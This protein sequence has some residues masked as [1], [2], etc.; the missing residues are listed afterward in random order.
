MLCR[1]AASFSLQG[2]LYLAQYETQHGDKYNTLLG[3]LRQEKMINMLLVSLKKRQSVLTWSQ[4]VS[5][6]NWTVHEENS[7]TSDGICLHNGCRT[8][9]LWWISQST[10]MAAYTHSSWSWLCGKQL[11]VQASDVLFEIQL[12][13]TD[14]SVI[15]IWRIAP[16]GLDTFYQ[17]LL[18]GYNKLTAVFAKVLCMFGTPYLCEQVFSVMNVSKTKLCP[19]LTHKHLFMTL[20]H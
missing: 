6:E 18:P 2:I 7:E 19:W 20:W 4:E 3:Q 10:Y 8:L 15:W 14:Q 9:H 16:V 13:L 11:N 17:Y 12:E 5:E 1:Y